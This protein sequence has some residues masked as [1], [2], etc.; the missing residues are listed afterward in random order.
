M[1]LLFAL[2]TFSLNAQAAA[3]C[4]DQDLRMKGEAQL[5][6][7]TPAA[8]YGLTPDFLRKA[9]QLY[10]R[11]EVNEAVSE[12]TAYDLFVART[13][14]RPFP[15][16]AAYHVA[17]EFGITQYFLVVTYPRAEGTKTALI[18]HRVDHSKASFTQ[19]IL[20]TK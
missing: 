2:L 12:R 19:T 3:T 7:F 17:Y 9:I 20:C 5:T 4:T 18:S 6:Q 15:T 16:I 11:M 1:T 13:W 10:V 8:S 14:A